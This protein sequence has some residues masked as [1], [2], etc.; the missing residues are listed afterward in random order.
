MAVKLTKGSI[1]RLEAGAKDMI[2]WDAELKGFG[3]RVTPAGKITFVVQ[4][5]VNGHRHGVRISIGSYQAVPVDEAR[6]IAREHLRTMRLGGDPREIGKQREASTV[7]LQRVCDDYVSRPG[8]L[9]PSSIAAIER[10]VATTFAAWKDKPIASITPAMCR[11]RYREMLTG[12]LRGKRGAPGQANHAF[13]ILS[14]LI[15][16]A[17]RQHR[18]PDGTPLISENP[19]SILKDDRVRLLARKSYIPDHSVGACWL[20]LERWSLEARTRDAQS[21]IDLVR[22]ILLTGLRIGEASTLRWDQINLEDRWFRIPNP[23]NGNAVSM[24]ISR[25]TAALLN[26]RPRG[27]GSPFVFPSWGAAGHIKRPRDT[28]QNLRVIAGNS[29]TPHDLRRT[30]THI[31]LRQCRIEKYRVDLLTNHLTRDVTS[32]HYFDTANLQWLQPEA[33]KIADWLDR[34]ARAAEAKQAASQ[35]R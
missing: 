1:A 23:K 22:L 24:P 14:A 33:Q 11:A 27:E 16:Y 29:L 35:S 25:Q 28:M 19:V 12:G 20:A 9:K 5:R 3:V 21:S 18:R 15:N 13:S 32:M 4:G 6:N 26:A 7:S 10:H 34:E 31:A 17:R 2:H 30:Y 8:R